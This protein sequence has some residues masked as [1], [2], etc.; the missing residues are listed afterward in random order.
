MLR[1]E[2][3]KSNFS[4]KQILILV[5]IWMIIGFIIRFT[6]LTAKPPWT[7]EFATMVF[8]L[9]NDF[10]SVPINQLFSVETLLQPLKIN[11]NATI[12]DVISLIVKEDNHPPLYF[13]LC[14]WWVKLFPTDGEYVSL[15]AMRSLPALFGVLAIPLSYLLGKIAF[16]SALAGQFSAAM[17]TVSP[18]GIYLA[19]EAR[20]YTLGVLFVIATLC[21]LI[22]AIW[23]LYERRLIAIGLVMGWI[24]INSLGLATHY[25]FSIT[26]G[27]I[28][29]TLFGFLVYQIKSKNFYFNNWLRVGIVGLG[30][31]STAAVWFL[32]VVPRDYGKGMI[33]WLVHYVTD[34]LSFISPIVQLIVG[35]IV[36][37]SLLP[38]E[39]N[40]LVIV[41]L[42]ALGMLIFFIW[43][44][45]LFI[46]IFKKAWQTDYRLGLVGLG[47]FFISANFL[48]LFI[49]YVLTLDI[50]KAARYNFTYFPAV[51]ALMGVILAILWKKN[52]IKK[53]FLQIKTG[54]QA[55]II[56]LIMG[57]LSSL[58]VSYNLGY[59]KYYL[60]NQFVEVMQQNSSE[61]ILIATPYRSLVQVGEMMGIARELEKASMT[62]KIS[63]Y[64]MPDDSLN[65]VQSNL[66][67]LLSKINFSVDVW[68]INCTDKFRDNF[69]GKLQL[70]GCEENLENKKYINGYGYQHFQCYKPLP[71]KS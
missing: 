5:G 35:W 1:F 46:Q 67:N 60:P 17:M 54:R 18:Y 33:Y 14:H 30:T 11:S 42:S 56:I 43:A 25:F 66:Q 6:Q 40:S 31:L 63:F 20:H 13:I 69:E 15:F 51:I 28:L 70:Q 53:N 61:P 52:I 36:M 23:H 41:I 37:I 49:T 55:V 21:C 68:A 16:R 27:A 19:Q 22:S 2:F 10:K 48:F 58:T 64:L 32:T 4:R 24:I 47:G 65:K 8:S 3:D 50:T 26:L 7:D 12:N 57:F 39:A 45:P 59:R 44:I 62:E 34:F 9:G 38:I 71:I 29:L